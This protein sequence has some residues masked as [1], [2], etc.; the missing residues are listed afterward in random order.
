LKDFSHDQVDRSLSKI[1][2]PETQKPA[3]GSTQQNSIFSEK[4]IETAKNDNNPEVIKPL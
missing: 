1:R 4:F 2:K 3:Q